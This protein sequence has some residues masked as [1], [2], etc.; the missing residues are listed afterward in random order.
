MNQDATPYERTGRTAQKART[1]AALLTATSDF[2]DEGVSPTVEEAADRAGIS[3]T[4]AYRYFPNQRTLLAAI[5]PELDASSLLGPD[6]PD[7]V[8]TRLDLT[9]DRYLEHLVRRE[10]AQRTQ[11]RLSL[12][13]RRGDRAGNRHGGPPLPLRQGRAI[14]WLEDAL[15]PLRDHMTAAE[16]HRLAL[17]IR[18][19]TGIESLVWLTD[20]A[21]L[22]RPDAIALMRD[23]ARALLRA[24]LDAAPQP[25][26]GVTR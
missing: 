7:D 24:A 9:L 16:V 25:P 20:I 22:S 23:S 21:G 18:A 5:V 4:T 6:A 2:L 11:L 26:P 15:A 13:P 12:E 1:R 10:A 17:S 8:Q 14:V 3:R 19:T